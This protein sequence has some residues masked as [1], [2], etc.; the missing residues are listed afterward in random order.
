MSISAIDINSTQIKYEF[1]HLNAVV[2]HSSKTTFT[3]YSIKYGLNCNG[4][5]SRHTKSVLNPGYRVES[6]HCHKR[7]CILFHECQFS[8]WIAN[9]N[10]S[11]LVRAVHSAIV[12]SV[13]G[14]KTVCGIRQIM[15]DAVTPIAFDREKCILSFLLFL[16][17]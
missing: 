5:L 11:E 4:N 7:R 6:S 15:C 16:N 2:L 17:Y 3:I 8:I 10:D 13:L 12:E 9:G 14:M 1:M